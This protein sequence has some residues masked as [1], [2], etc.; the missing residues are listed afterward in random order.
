M[1]CCSVL[2]FCSEE[3]E[4]F[5]ASVPVV[6][7]FHRLDRLD[8]AERHGFCSMKLAA[9]GRSEIGLHSLDRS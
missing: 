8:S 7:L 5:L 6:V 1:Y 9:T 4:H 3:I 2:V